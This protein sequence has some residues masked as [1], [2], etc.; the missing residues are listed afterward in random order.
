MNIYIYRHRTNRYFFCITNNSMCT[1]KKIVHWLLYLWLQPCIYG[2]VFPSI[3]IVLT[4]PSKNSF[5]RNSDVSLFCFK[6]RTIGYRKM[7]MSYIIAWHGIYWIRKEN[8]NE[9]RVNMIVPILF[10]ELNSETYRENKWKSYYV[11]IYIFPNSI[12]NIQSYL[13]N[14]LLIWYEI[15]FP[16]T[17]IICLM[18]I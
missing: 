18:H 8:M 7:I 12:I 9:N 11:Y 6:G 1:L 10:Y 3:F 13:N 17:C 16:T 4:L 15:N 2:Q 5:P 14:T